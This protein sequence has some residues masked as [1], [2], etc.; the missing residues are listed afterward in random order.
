MQAYPENAFD[1]GVRFLLSNKVIGITTEGG[2]VKTVQTTGEEL[3]TK[4]I[5]NCV[6]LYCD[7]IAEM[8][9]KGEYK[10]VARK[11]PFFILDKN[12]SCQVNH[13][14]LLIPTKI[15]RASIMAPGTRPAGL[16]TAGSAQACG[17]LPDHY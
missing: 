7:D 5:I 8:V 14:V 1:N 2:K 4:Y 11:G 16:Y 10:I 15:P 13:I 6:G 9:G 17:F 3:E 12:T